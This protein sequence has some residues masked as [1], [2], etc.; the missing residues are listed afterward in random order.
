MAPCR[1]N[2]GVGRQK[3]SGVEKYSGHIRV[4]TAAVA[5]WSRPSFVNG[6]PEFKVGCPQAK[7]EN[8]EAAATAVTA[9]G[10]YHF[11]AVVGCCCHLQDSY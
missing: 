7:R 4:A 8:E 6:L 5:A 11:P 3:P 9:G 2:E 10:E 1:D